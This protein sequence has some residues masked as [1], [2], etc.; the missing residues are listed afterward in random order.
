MLY[1]LGMTTDQ[2]FA[3]FAEEISVHGGKVTD[4]F[5]DGGRL[6]TRSV[7]AQS[8]E[9]RPGDTVQGGV[10]L[11]ATDDEICLYP[12]LFR[13]VCTNGAIM[14]QTLGSR[15]VADSDSWEPDLVVQAIREGVE[16]CTDEA[17]KSNVEKMQI[18]STV[19]ADLALNL[20]P[21][22]SLLSRHSGPELLSQVMDRFFSGGD[23][24]RFG[25]VNAI[26][27]WARD[28]G[29]PALKWELEKYGGSVAFG[30]VAEQPFS[31]EREVASRA[32]RLIGVGGAYAR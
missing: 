28:T 2:V 10:S 30:A 16:A 7:L 9:V 24:T 12:Y 26:T 32:N 1:R 17:F 15:T 3:V 31:R 18:S 20:L 8:G 5:N 13:L 6:F 21:L 27:S 23:Q 25:L 22:A 29:D 19:E 11:K 4:T 14:A